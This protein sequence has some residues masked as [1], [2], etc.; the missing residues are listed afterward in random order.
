[1]SAVDPSKVPKLDYEKLASFPDGYSGSASVHFIPVHPL[2]DGAPSEYLAYGQSAAYKIK[3][4]LPQGSGQ[5][6]DDFY[7]TF[8]AWLEGKDL[9]FMKVALGV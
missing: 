6:H 5:A 1:M 2:T 8:I 7:Q 9:D 4:D 3:L